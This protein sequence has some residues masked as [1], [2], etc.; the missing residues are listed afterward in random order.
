MI[1]EVVELENFRNYKKVKVNIDPNLVLV[2]GDNAAGKTNF[3]ESIYF[4][5]RLASF[6]V[7]DNLLVNSQE[8]YF[9]I[10]AKTSTQEF[11][12]VVQR[13]P[14]LKRGFKINQL[15][16]KRSNWNPFHV[17]LFVPTDLNMFS[18]GPAA[19]RKYLND[20]IS[21]TDKA[22]AADLVSLEHILKQ[23]AALLEDIYQNRQDP[24]QLQFWNDQLADVAL[25]ITKARRDLL[26]FLDK[27]FNTQ[28][29][30]LTEFDN[31]FN[32][33]YKGLDKDTDRDQF[34]EILLAH[35]DAEIRSGKNLIGPHRDDFVIEKDGELN[36]YNS[37]RGELREQI[38]TIKLLQAKYLSTEKNKPIILLDDVFSEL[39]ETRRAK[40]LE[41]L[42]GY[43]IFITSTEEHHLPKLA[44]KAQILM[45]K[46]NNIK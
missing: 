29:L 42:L 45:V 1:L 13:F 9:K 40:L 16:T 19:R 3:I 2:L 6:R 12:A 32:I 20:T 37:S 46:D 31:K 35:Q 18:L 23:R 25:R 4:L 41:N 5:S 15:K 28:Y 27:E 22:H 44:Q 26:G 10:I 33:V 21:Q 34:L 14:I 24:V 39:D 11:E 7:N 36:V 38:L 30:D 17:V 43:Q 8:D